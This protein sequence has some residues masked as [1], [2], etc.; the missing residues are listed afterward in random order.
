MKINVDERTTVRIIAVECIILENL[1]LAFKY[2]YEW[3]YNFP[4]FHLR[5]DV[6]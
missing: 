4:E 1:R 6:E 3:L 5:I 2:S